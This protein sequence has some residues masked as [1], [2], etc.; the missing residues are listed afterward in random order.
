MQ[1]LSGGWRSRGRAGGAAPSSVFASPSAPSGP[2]TLNAQRCAN[3]RRGGPTGVGAVWPGGGLSVIGAVHYGTAKVFATI[4]P[5]CDP[6]GFRHSLQQVM[7][8][9]GHTGTE[10]V[11]VVDRS[12]IHR[13]H[14]LASTLTHWHEQFRLSRLPARYGHHLNPIEGFWR[15]RKDRIGAGRCFPALQSFTSARAACSWRIKS[16]RSLRFTGDRFCLELRRSCSSCG[17]CL[18]MLPSP[19]QPCAMR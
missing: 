12:G 17:L 15:V 19:G 13:A 4:V 9:F 6:E 1:P 2:A 5:Q 14:Q 8:L 16:D 10:V 18:S 7:A 11:M 3:V